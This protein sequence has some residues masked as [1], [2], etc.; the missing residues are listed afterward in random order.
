MAK[1]HDKYVVELKEVIK[2]YGNDP[3]IKDPANLPCDYKF[4]EI[5]GVAICEESLKKM[6]PLNTILED[7]KAEIKEYR[8]GD[9]EASE[10]DR[11]RAEAYNYGLETALEI[12]D[13][14]M[15]AINKYC[16]ENTGD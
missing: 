9:E 12:I 3:T 5:D 13:K 15:G 1:I 7:I 8:Y 2:G 4:Y 16:K 14:H 11:N 10:T 6:K